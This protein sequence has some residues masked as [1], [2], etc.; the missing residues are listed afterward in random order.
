MDANPSFAANCCFVEDI[1]SCILV[2]HNFLNRTSK[3]LLDIVSKFGSRCANAALNISRMS[4]RDPRTLWAT[5]RKHKYSVE[6]KSMYHTLINSEPFSSNPS[7]FTTPFTQSSTAL[8]KEIK[9][10]WG[11]YMKPF[12]IFWNCWFVFVLMAC[13]MTISWDR[14][15]LG[16]QSSS[17]FDYSAT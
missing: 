15:S 2:L 10:A 16:H 11:K 1:N 8:R 3:T 4:E 9:L 17:W 5:Y 13:N 14:Q 12:Q 7:E 6:L